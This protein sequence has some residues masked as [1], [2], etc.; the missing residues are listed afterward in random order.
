MITCS[1]C[2][3]LLKCL[4]C[5]TSYYG[6]FFCFFGM[7]PPRYPGL[8]GEGRRDPFVF[9]FRRL[10]QIFSDKGARTEWC[11]EFS[12]VKTMRV[13]KHD[14]RHPVPEIGTQSASLLS[15][16]AN[17]LSLNFPPVFSMQFH[18]TPFSPYLQRNKLSPFARSPTASQAVMEPSISLPFFSPWK[19]F[20]FF[21]LPVSAIS[22]ER[23]GSLNS[24][25]SNCP[26]T[27]REGAGEEEQTREIKR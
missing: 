6:I 7:S 18:R 23:A 17:R 11:N 19:M 5:S 12:L 9:L 14:L 26:C 21:L 8:Q 2:F 24:L 22:Q 25:S 27:K 20:F 13:F 3:L 1:V 15:E 10:Q 4:C 16:K